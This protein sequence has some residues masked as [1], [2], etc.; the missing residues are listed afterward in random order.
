VIWYGKGAAAGKPN[1]GGYVEGGPVLLAECTLEKPIVKF[2]GLAERMKQVQ[3]QIG[4]EAN[5]LA[6]VFTRAQT[7]DSEKEQANE[8][9]VVLVR[10]STAYNRRTKV[11]GRISRW[12][13]VT[14]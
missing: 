1:L 14:G 2:S 10:R 4:T 7:V 8:H 5:S 3:A 9:G 11:V 12:S 13:S 6:V